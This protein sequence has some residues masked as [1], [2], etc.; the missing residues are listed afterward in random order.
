MCEWVGPQEPEFHSPP[1][2]KY[3]K[4]INVHG[5]EGVGWEGGGKDF[6]L[7]WKDCKKIVDLFVFYEKHFAEP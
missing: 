7:S 1:S 2:N 5:V 6:H 3:Q 4:T